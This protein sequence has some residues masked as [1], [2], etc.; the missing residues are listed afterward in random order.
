MIR[1]SGWDRATNS[2]SRPSSIPAW[3][4]SSSDSG[5]NVGCCTREPVAGDEPSKQSCW[6]WSL[7]RTGRGAAGCWSGSPDAGVTC[8]SAGLLT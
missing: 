6:N 3:G 1:L 7:D 8:S 5:T 2:A 4:A